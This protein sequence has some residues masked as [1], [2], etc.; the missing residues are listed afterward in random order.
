MLSSHMKMHQHICFKLFWFVNAAWPVQISLLIQTRPLYHWRKQYFG[1]RTRILARS[2][3]LKLK[4]SWWICFR[5][6]LLKMLTDVDIMLTGVVWIIVMFLSAVWT[7]ILTAPIHCRASI[8]EKW[9]N[10]TFLQIWW[11][12]K[13]IYILDDLRMRKLSFWLKYSFNTVFALS[14]SKCL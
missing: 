4:M 6:C 12:T 9:C 13:I 7:L 11:K 1:W 3:G 14:S 10:A 8:C 5:F 2:N